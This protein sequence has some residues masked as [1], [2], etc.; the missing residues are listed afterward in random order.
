MRVDETKYAKFEYEDGHGNDGEPKDNPFK[1]G[2]VVFKPYYSDGTD[3]NEV[4]VVLQ[5]H[6]QSELRTD[7]FGNECTDNLTMATSVD[8]VEYR[9][10]L[11]LEMGVG[12]VVLK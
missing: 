6:D 12:K 9:P 3:C 5:V 8:I 7:M 11:A 2:D 1:R 4:G 10:K